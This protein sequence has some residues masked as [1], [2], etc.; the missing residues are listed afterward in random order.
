[1]LILEFCTSIKSIRTGHNLS[2]WSTGID[3][4]KAENHKTKKPV[5][6]MTNQEKGIFWMAKLSQVQD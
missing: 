3:E 6:K 1:M 5:F 2:A 4:N